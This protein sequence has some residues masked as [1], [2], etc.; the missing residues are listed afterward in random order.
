MVADV[1]FVLRVLGIDADGDDAATHQGGE[2]LL[3]VEGGV[4]AL[5][6]GHVDQGG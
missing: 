5:G 2:A 4:V 3:V 6:L 1:W